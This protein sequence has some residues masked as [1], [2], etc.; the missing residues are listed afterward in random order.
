MKFSE[1]IKTIQVA[2]TMS[3][4]GKK[5][6]HYCWPK[7]FI[8]PAPGCL[9]GE[10]SAQPSVNLPVK[11][12]VKTVKRDRKRERIGITEILICLIL[13]KKDPAGNGRASHAEL[14]SQPGEK[15]NELNRTRTEGL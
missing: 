14:E 9:H 12:L 7:E 11:Q 15:G 2:N 10:Q 4:L 8:S 6:S 3:S 13:E 1:C 5:E